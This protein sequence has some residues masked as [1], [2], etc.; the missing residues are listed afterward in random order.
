DPTVRALA[1]TW[2][3]ELFSTADAVG[4]RGLAEVLLRLSLDNTIDVQRAAVLAL[5]NVGDVRAFERLRG[6]LRRGEPPIRAAAARAL[7][8]QTK[9]VRKK[10]TPA[11]GGA[12]TGG[13]AA[14]GT[15]AVPLLQKALEDPALEVVMEAAEAL[16]S[17]GLP[18]AVPVLT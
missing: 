15:Q 13:Q 17:L 3:T 10:S 9:L 16:G 12:T 2:G 4:Q 8:Q 11:S 7:V 18:E 6:L 14:S 5:G 1:V